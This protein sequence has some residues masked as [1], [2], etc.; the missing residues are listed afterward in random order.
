M[1]Q[2]YSQFKAMM[3]ITKA[4]LKA[5]FRSPQAVFFSLF[6]PVVLIV[7][8][9]ALSSRGGISVDVA[10]EKNADTTNMLYQTLTHIPVLHI[11]DGTEEELM[12]R[13]KKGRIT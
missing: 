5:M 8:F 9:G 2:P 1:P 4:S 12:D 13:L 11:E 7:I 10:F 6:F 3:A